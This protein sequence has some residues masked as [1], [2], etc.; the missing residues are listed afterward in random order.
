MQSYFLLVLQLAQ[1]FN[2]HRESDC[3]IEIILHLYERFGAEVRSC[4]F[5]C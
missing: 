2:F 4:V 1:E 3:D 5:P